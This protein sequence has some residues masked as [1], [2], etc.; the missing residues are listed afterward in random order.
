[1]RYYYLKIGKHNSLV[2]PLLVN[3]KKYGFKNPS[4]AIFFGNCTLDDLKN[5]KENVDEQAINFYKWCD[6]KI[7][8]LAIVV[9]NSKIW[10][11]EPITGGMEMIELN[12]FLKNV[13]YEHG[14][15]DDIV[16]LSPVNVLFTDVLKNIPV[17]LANIGANQYLSQGTFRKIEERYFGNILAIESLLRK[18]GI[19]NTFSY[20]GSSEEVTFEKILT[21]LA[22]IEL[23]TLIAK[24]LEENKLF[25]PAYFGGTMKDIDLFAYNKSNESI[26]LDELIVKPRDRISM[27]IKGILQTPLEKKLSNVDYFFQIEGKLDHDSGLL[28]AEWLKRQLNKSRHTKQWLL[29]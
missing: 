27:Q 14:S 26:E 3:Y 11:L 13:P 1:M 20:F 22:S 17:V 2:E 28:N 9:S 8:A 10:I 19:I 12:E 15:T 18:N 5:E 25:V 6:G 4:A 7:K 21:C 16:K 29:D 24:L 23:E